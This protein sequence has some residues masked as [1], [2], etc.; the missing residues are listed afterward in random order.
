LLSSVI[1]FVG[2]PFVLKVLP[3][4]ISVLVMIMS[5]LLLLVALLFG[6]VVIHAA[7][8]QWLQRR[9][10]PEGR[11]S[12]SMALFFGAAFWTLMLSLPYIWP[13]I[14]AGLVIASLGL[15]LTARYRVTWKRVQQA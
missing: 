15:A 12:E 3:T 14:V 10:C 2:I 8:G 5:L 7:T 9:L 4:P 11:R 1:V 13:V 6:R